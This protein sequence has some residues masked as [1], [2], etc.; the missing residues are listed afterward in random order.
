MR[1][2]VGCRMQRDGTLPVAIGC[3]P[4][5]TQ[6]LAL[7]LYCMLIKPKFVCRQHLLDAICSRDVE[8]R[9]QEK[10]AWAIAYNAIH[11]LVATI[12]TNTT[13]LRVHIRFDQSSDTF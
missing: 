5:A 6:P 9:D 4:W 11:L 8:V 12:L 13:T 2:I 3:Q 7:L 10:T 1:A